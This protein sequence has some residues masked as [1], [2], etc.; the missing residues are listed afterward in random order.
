MPTPVL[1]RPEP[2]PLG[3]CAV[4]RPV[5]AAHGRRAC[6]DLAFLLALA[7]EEVCEA[8]VEYVTAGTPLTVRMLYLR[9]PG[10]DTL[11]VGCKLIEADSATA[12]I[13][14]TVNGAGATFV[15]ANR[16]DGSSAI[17]CPATNTSRQPVYWC[18][19]D[20]SGLA[21]GGTVHTIEVGYVRTASANGLRRAF[22]REIP[23][24]AVDPVSD[25]TTEVAAN[26][27]WPYPRRGQR[28]GLIDGSASDPM[29]WVRLEAQLAS[30]RTLVRIHRAWATYEDDTYAAQTASAAMGPLDWKSGSW[31]AGDDPT[32]VTRSR[33]YYGT[34]AGTAVPE[35]CRA[36][37]R[38]KCG[39]TGGTVRFVINGANTDFAVIAAAG[40][41]TKSLGALA[42]PTD[43]AGQRVTIQVNG[44]VTTTG[45]LRICAWCVATDEA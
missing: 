29:G 20:V 4:G 13:T 7:T 42:L 45:S 30:V 18:T 15:V 14:V 28:D 39:G 5:S 11:L 23:Q 26:A 41:T 44:N 17:D 37:I 35:V 8:D 36:L 2:L 33:R 27:S 6:E 43:Q 19:V 1:P 16:L 9:S 40:W 32:F 38:Y 3:V 10:C 31:T 24:A 22:V 34:T 12:T 21:L 25:P